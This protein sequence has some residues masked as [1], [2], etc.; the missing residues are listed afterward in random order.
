[1]SHAKR[2]STRKRRRKAMPVLEAAGFLALAS[3]ASE[4]GLRSFLL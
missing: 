1:M 3:G 4:W 2:V